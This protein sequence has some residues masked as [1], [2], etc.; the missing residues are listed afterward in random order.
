MGH[1]V[2]GRLEDYCTKMEQLCCE[3]YG[4]TMA[5]ARYYHILGF[6]HFSDNNKNGVDR[7]DDRMWIIRVLFKIIRTKFL[8]FYNPSE[9]LSIDEVIVKSKGSVVFK[10]YVPNKSKRFGIKTFKLC[11]STRYTYDMK[12]YHGKDRQRDDQHL[13]AKHATVTNL[14]M[15]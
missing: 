7:T 2:Q 3:F 10:Q 9:H 12:F 8:K 4:R 11:D 13:T 6:L 1:R 5:L 15:G 14:T